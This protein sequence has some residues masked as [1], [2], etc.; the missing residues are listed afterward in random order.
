[1]LKKGFGYLFLLFI[2]IFFLYLGNQ[3]A[4]SQ[5]SS[6]IIYNK[7][8]ELDSMQYGQVISI[9]Q[10]D[11]SPSDPNYKEITFSA[12]LFTDSGNDGETVRAKQI[13][14][15][16][17][18]DQMEIEVDDKVAL[19]SYGSDYIFQYYYRLDKIILLGCVFVGLVLLMGRVKGLQTVLALGLTCCSIFYV[20][21]PLIC[22][23]YNIY[24]STL[25]ICIYII[26]A[27]FGIVYGINQKSLVA[28]TSCLF[29]VIL[30]NVIV[31][32]M[33]KSM[34]LT[35]Y[36][37]ENSYLLSDLLG[38]KNLDVKAILYAMI[39]IGAMG[40]IMDVSMSITSSLNELKTN[41]HK[42][43][44]LELIQSGFRIGKDI[45]GT[46]M[47]TLILAYIGSSL[48]VV[49]V[50]ASSHY[51][52]LSLLNKEEIIYEFLQSLIGSLCLLFTMPISTLISSFVFSGKN[53]SQRMYTKSLS[54]NRKLH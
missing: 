9:E 19:L 54:H 47:N 33:D 8:T 50:Y 15:G 32:L 17:K 40:A 46:M 25:I 30:S 12:V 23:G 28:A 26:V 20:F 41:N 7:E 43:T 44:C 21:I 18:S 2:L 42:I 11:F 29:G 48:T 51:P 53:P 49:L 52:L 6:G 14:N 34:K 37:N 1:M 3:F 45:L 13:I 5:T 31:L 35:G 10:V 38:I 27:T 4:V 36:I 39:T 24:L 16:S 22:A